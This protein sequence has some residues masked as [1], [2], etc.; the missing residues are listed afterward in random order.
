M[1][2]GFVSPTYAATTIAPGGTV[3]VRVSLLT[4]AAAEAELS[5]RDVTNKNLGWEMDGD[6]VWVDWTGSSLTSAL[7]YARFGGSAADCPTDESAER[8][9]VT[10]TAR[11][12]R[13]DRPRRQGGGHRPRAGR[14]RRAEGRQR[15]PRHRD[16]PGPAGLPAVP[17]VMRHDPADPNWLGR[18]RFVLSCG[19]SSLTLYIQLYLGGFGLELDDLKALRTWGS[20]T[21]GTRSSATPRVWRSPPARS[22][23]AWPPRSAWRWRPAERGLFDPDAA[24]GREPFDHHIYVSPPTATSRRA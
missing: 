2:R 17:A 24:P 21:P 12:A 19:H 4:A 6:Q 1:T 3:G 23:R 5:R 8:N 20:K 13:L 14:R 7:E 18:D 15:P 16:E 9:P 22:A 10:H 11:Q